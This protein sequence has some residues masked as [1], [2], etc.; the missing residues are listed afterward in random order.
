MDLEPLTILRWGLQTDLKTH[1]TFWAVNAPLRKHTLAAREK[2]NQFCLDQ[3]HHFGLPKPP[4]PVLL[5]LGLG[6]RPDSERRST[7]VM[8]IRLFGYVRRLA[9]PYESRTCLTDRKPLRKTEGTEQADPR[10]VLWCTFSRWA[11]WACRVLPSPLSCPFSCASTRVCMD[12]WRTAAENWSLLKGHKEKSYFSAGS[13]FQVWLPGSAFT[14]HHPA[15]K[16]K[17]KQEQGEGPTHLGCFSSPPAEGN[18]QRRFWTRIKWLHEC[19]ELLSLTAASPPYLSIT[20]V[21]LNISFI[22]THA[23][24]RINQVLSV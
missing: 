5:P 3:S 16:M 9:H 23:I 10:A 13:A 18:L 4:N 14:H 8:A 11:G 1:K 22:S 17:E 7:L 6:S 12:V 24:T 15:E 20:Y 21:S 2:I 19:S